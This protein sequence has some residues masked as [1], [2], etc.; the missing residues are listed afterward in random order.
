[1]TPVDIAAHVEAFE[2]FMVKAFMENRI[3]VETTDEATASEFARR[4][5]D[6]TSAAESFLGITYEKDSP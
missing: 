2:R 4:F 6:L 3:S 1:M 5:T